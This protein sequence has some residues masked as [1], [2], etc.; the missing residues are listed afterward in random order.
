VGG[1]L[2]APKLLRTWPEARVRLTEDSS[3]PHKIRIY[4]SS[5][6]EYKYFRAT[7]VH[8]VKLQKET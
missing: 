6:G 4:N 2:T 5:A 8:M 7:K 3:H 1:S